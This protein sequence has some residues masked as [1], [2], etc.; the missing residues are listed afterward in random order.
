MKTCGRPTRRWRT[1]RRSTRDRESEARPWTLEIEPRQGDRDAYGRLLRYVI[2][3]DGANFNEEMVRKGYAR[4]YDRFQFT[5]KPR[6]KEAESEAKRGR[7]GVWSLPPG[8]WRIVP[9]R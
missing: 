3:G 5:L 4:V 1:R 2:L 6:F 8:K 9:P 7:L